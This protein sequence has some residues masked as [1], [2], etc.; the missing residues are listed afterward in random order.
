MNVKTAKGRMSK[1]LCTQM[2]RS[3]MRTKKQTA[4]GHG[5][6]YGIFFHIHKVRTLRGVWG[7]HQ[8]RTPYII[9]ILP[10][11]KAYRMGGGPKSANFQPTCF[12]EGPTW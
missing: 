6:F 9:T 11:P 7:A 10:I 12:I 2:V 1:I 8:T 5:T 4:V 3:D